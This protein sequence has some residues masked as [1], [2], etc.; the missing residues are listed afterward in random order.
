MATN[1]AT[2]GGYPAPKIAAS[3]ALDAAVAR[4]LYWL[5]CTKDEEREIWANHTVDGHHHGESLHLKLNILSFSYE[6][7]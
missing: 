2:F 6:Y 5:C 1:R 4:A 7:K 3:E